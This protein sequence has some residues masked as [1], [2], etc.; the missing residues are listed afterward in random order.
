[1]SVFTSLSFLILVV[2]TQ[3]F[4]QL[5]SG[6]FTLFYHHALGK[7][8]KKRAADLSLSFI[9]GA[10]T[11]SVAL[12]L[13]CYFLIY[14]IFLNQPGFESSLPAWILAGV[15]IALA[16]FAFFFYFR[17][18][19]A[20]ALYIPRRL[21]EAFKN[22]AKLVKTR[23][24]AFALGAVASALESFFSLPLFLL[25]SVEIMR[26]DSS[27]CPRNLLA[28]LVVFLPLLPLFCIRTLF[29]TNH[30]LAEVERRRVA[31]KT[32]TRFALAFGYLALAILIIIFRIFNYGNF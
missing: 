29:R 7:N 9:T 10:L 1:M 4:L 5:P 8:S 12:F 16:I 13:T 20:T 22:H 30:T 14:A 2:L 21:A 3:S 15:L 31:S 28:F 19:S 6:V 18:S 27:P 11:A 23:S 25:A 17:K 32:F 24:D 26:L